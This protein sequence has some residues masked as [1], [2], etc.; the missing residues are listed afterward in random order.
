[1]KIGDT[2]G[3]YVLTNNARRVGLRIGR[4][5]KMFDLNN[6]TMV[7]IRRNDGSKIVNAI[8]ACH[9]VRPLE[10]KMKTLNL[11]AFL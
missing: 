11:D 7:V 4:V 1:M 6:T 10:L 8:W 5:E 2:I 3:T 9:I